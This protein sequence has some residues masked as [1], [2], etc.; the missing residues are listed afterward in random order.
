[1]LIILVARTWWL[2]LVQVAAASIAVISAFMWW[3]EARG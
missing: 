3:R 2:W 1:V